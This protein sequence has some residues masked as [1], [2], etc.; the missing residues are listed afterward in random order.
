MNSLR[1]IGMRYSDLSGMAVL[2]ST[3]RVE[4]PKVNF[5][6]DVLHLREGSKAGQA[7]LKPFIMYE[8]ISASLLVAY[9]P[10]KFLFHF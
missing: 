8:L 9:I 7:K 4:I 10:E 2:P 3:C 1:T 6:H 5:S